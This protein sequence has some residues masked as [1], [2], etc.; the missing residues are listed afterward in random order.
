M[1]HQ[2]RS[3]GRAGATVTVA[4]NMTTTMKKD[5]FLAN[6][7]NKQQFIFMLGR[8]LEK[9]N[10]KTYHASGDAD[11]LIVQKAV[12]SATTSNTVL[13]GDDTDLIVLLCY[14]AKLES[15]DL[16]FRPEPKKNTKK[17]RI[18]N[19]KATKEKLGQDICSNILFIHAFLGC[20]TTSRLYG[21]GKGTSLSKFKAS[22]MFREQAKVFNSDSASTCEVV[23]AGEKALIL[24]Y[25]GKLPD[26]LDSLR[27]K[28]FCEKVASKTSHVKPQSLP[29]TSAAAKYHS[30]RVYLQ[31]KEWKGSADGL[32]PA[33]WGWR[34]CEEGFVPLQT[35]L[36][37]APEHLL[38]IIRCNCQTDC[39]TLR[40]SCKKHN[41]ECNPACGN[42]KGTG[43]TNI[44]HDNDTDDVETFAS[45][46]NY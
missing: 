7:K 41:I 37:P 46:T 20:D 31:V 39:S 40:C 9:N 5:Q 38:Q 18:W 11:L 10:C 42:C 4:S 34:E 29:P 26:T 33:D 36:P 15:Y 12:Q 19:I 14:H 1:T 30:L 8:E 43:C 21:I 17:L 25:N 6:R 44:S 28:R 23:D 22:S 13:V 45:Q 27:H 3:K 16:F 24:V 2:R 35:S 32:H